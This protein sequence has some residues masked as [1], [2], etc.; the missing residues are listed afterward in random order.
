LTGNGLTGRLNQSQSGIYIDTELGSATNAVVP[1]NAGFQG[2]LQHVL[3]W[4][5]AY[6]GATKDFA[7]S[8]C[9][10][11]PTAV[12]LSRLWGSAECSFHLGIGL[13]IPNLAIHW[14][15]GKLPP[16]YQHRFAQHGI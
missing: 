11:E 12:G 3:S 6:A 5:P 2:T 13:D 9:A 14:K 8:G 7:P 4:A 1:A 16:D 10:N 15:G